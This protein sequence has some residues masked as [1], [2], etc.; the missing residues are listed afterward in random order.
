MS[1]GT[2]S[3]YRHFAADGA[4]LYVGISLSWPARTKAHS[5]GARWFDQVARVEIEH[6]PDRASA[7]DAEREAIRAERPK[8]N[9]VHNRPAP[10][11]P[12][13]PKFNAAAVVKDPALKH[14]TGP[15]AI[16]GP[17]LI[18]QDGKWSVMV[19]HGNP[20]TEGRLTEIVLGDVEAEVPDYFY[21][22]CANVLVVRNANEISRDEANDLRREIIGKLRK[23]LRSVEV[24]DT[25]LSLAVAYAARFPSP[26][27]RKVLDQIAT[28]RGATV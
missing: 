1:T 2:T 11:R 13:R 16:V 26:G 8:F 10:V 24:Y 3:L 19:A 18:Y 28:E 15:V 14:I 25:D 7:L 27:S 22:A 20:G 21:H 5:K 12:Q 6:F 9:I 4:L 17:A 23:A